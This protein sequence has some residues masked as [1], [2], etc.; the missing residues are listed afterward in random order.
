MNIFNSRNLIAMGRH[1][2]TPFFLEVADDTGKVMLKI[3]SILR[4][5]PG[6]RIVARSSWKNQDVVV[7]LFF[8]RGHWK[9]SMLRDLKGVT[10][11]RQA[12]I[13]TPKVINQTTT[14]DRQCAVMLIEFLK[15]A[16]SLL[17]LFEGA[18]SD[19]EKTS[20]ME[21]GVGAIARCHNAGLWQHDIHLGNF[22]LSLGKVY[23]L[24]GGDIKGDGN[25]LDDA[26][27][28]DNLATFFAQFPLDMDL[29]IPHLFT[30]YL[31]TAS[32]QLSGAADGMPRLQELKGRVVT[33]RQRRVRAF[34]R[35]IF[36][37]TTAHRQVKTSNRFAVYDRAIH[38]AAIEKFIEDPDS[39]LASAKML[40][41]GNSSTVAMI[42]FGGRD[43]VLKRYNV[44]GFLHGLKR[45]LQH[46][47]AHNSWRNA[48]MLEMLGV[49]TPHAYLMIEERVLWL[50]RRR[51]WYLSEYINAEN[52]LEQVEKDQGSKLPVAAIVPRFKQLFQVL[53]TYH[54]SHGDMKASNFIYRDDR[55]FVLDLDAMK[56]H[57]TADSARPLIV[58]DRERF[59]RNWAGTPFESSVQQMLGD[60]G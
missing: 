55:L 57:A 43:F 29:Q 35:K 7:K 8:R 42:Q 12:G 56:H 37:S 13:P 32:A 52:L 30:H 58:K 16:T 54:I 38:S 20:I 60:L 26:V 5:V 15:Q 6:K 31:K 21:M 34:E 11:L 41:E 40:K 22:M 48:A 25:P 17:T 36:R 2:P 44:K 1:I 33:A 3:D 53:A 18:G 24:D 39:M 47:R 49:A 19:E 46:S 45:L 10:L 50:L 23:V 4:I 28:L 59:S 27:C 51:A 14:S 9:Q